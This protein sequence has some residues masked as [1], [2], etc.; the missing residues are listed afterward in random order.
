MTPEE[1]LQ[2]EPLKYSKSC[3]SVHRQIGIATLEPVQKH[4][5]R[6]AEVDQS[7]FLGSAMPLPYSHALRVCRINRKTDDIGIECR[8]TW[9]SVS[10]PSAPRYCKAETHSKAK[11]PNSRNRPIASVR[12]CCAAAVLARSPSL[13]KYSEKLGKS[14]SVETISLFSG[15]SATGIAFPSFLSRC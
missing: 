4:K 7:F 5:I 2:L 14:R 6:I 15:R 12:I 11:D 13:H 1:Q 8:E 9:L 10:L 3:S